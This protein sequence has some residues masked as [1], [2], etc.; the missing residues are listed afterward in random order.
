MAFQHF[1]IWEMRNFWAGTRSETTTMH[2]NF[3]PL[4]VKTGTDVHVCVC[5]LLAQIDSL[6][7]GSLLP[8]RSSHTHTHALRMP[9]KAE[10]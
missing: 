1:I 8:H 9:G 7:I 6:E 2:D 4:A 10:A 3:L 5:V